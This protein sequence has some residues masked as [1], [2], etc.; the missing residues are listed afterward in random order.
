VL[1]ANTMLAS[2]W[3]WMLDKSQNAVLISERS[4]DVYA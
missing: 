3:V 2:V 4:V 1:G